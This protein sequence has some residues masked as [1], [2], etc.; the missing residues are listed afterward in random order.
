MIQTV[1]AEQN[2]RLKLAFRDV[3]LLSRLIENK[4][5][6][7]TIG[8]FFLICLQLQQISFHYSDHTCYVGVM[9]RI[10]RQ[11]NPFVLQIPD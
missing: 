10:G 7:I 6:L 2:G 3:K 9:R 8:W 1:Y 11:W 4:L 5:L